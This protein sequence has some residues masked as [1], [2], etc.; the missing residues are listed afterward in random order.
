M[1]KNLVLSYIPPALFIRPVVAGAVVSLK[2]QTCFN[3]IQNG[4][5]FLP[6]YDI[7]GRRLCKQSDLDDFIA[8]IKP[9]QVTPVIPTKR[10]G[11]P[12]K[13]AQIAAAALKSGGVK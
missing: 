1:P 6:L 7:A 8:N 13:A 10:R 11:R 9:I 12:T 2:P 4:K 3:H 5:F